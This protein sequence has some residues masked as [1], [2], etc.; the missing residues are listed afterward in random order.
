MSLGSASRPFI[1]LV[2][3]VPGYPALRRRTV[4]GLRGSA[5]ARRVGRAAFPDLLDHKQVD[6]LVRDAVREA[7]TAADKRARDAQ[8][9]AVREAV[10]AEQADAAAAMHQQRVKHST[11]LKE[12]RSE[13]KEKLRRTKADVAR[14][15]DRRR[16]ALP[17]V[18]AGTLVAGLYLADR[19]LI[20]FDVRGVTGPTAEEV[21]EEIAVEQVLG[22]AFR[23]MFLVD[24]GEDTAV[25]RRY[26]HVCEVIPPA[27][28]WSGS[29]P[30]EEY[31]AGRLESIRA[32]LGATWWVDIPPSGLTQTQRAFLRRCGR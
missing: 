5:S 9:T 29:L 25:W 7:L 2:K 23:P 22:C 1:R 19:P 3:A 15:E 8:D 14:K 18:S 30:Y 4:L 10:A 31:L 32:D 11:R 28:G 20:V 17:P 27:Q 24:Q 6:A 16:R 21:L 12:L 26:D 13:H